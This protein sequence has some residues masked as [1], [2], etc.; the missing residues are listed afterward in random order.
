MWCLSTCNSRPR[1]HLAD[2]D[3]DQ[4]MVK[5]A[6]LPQPRNYLPVFVATHASPIIDS[7]AQELLQAQIL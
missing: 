5:G 7:M 6:P 2:E 1:L 4:I 3:I